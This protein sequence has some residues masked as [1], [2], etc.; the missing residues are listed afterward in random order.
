MKTPTS[1]RIRRAATLTALLLPCAF[2]SV[3]VQAD[4]P[5]QPAVL[6]AD[7]LASA[8][9]AAAAEALATAFD[10]GIFDDVYALG[11]ARYRVDGATKVTGWR[12]NDGWYLGSQSGE[13]S[14]LTLVWQT[15]S[16]QMSL[17]KDGL[18][19]TRRF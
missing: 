9:A 18:R 12:L 6:V 8:Q 4:S 2:G 13:D 17:S 5:L 1:F 14:G 15:G 3:A 10:D 16:D 11:V 19:F 7:P